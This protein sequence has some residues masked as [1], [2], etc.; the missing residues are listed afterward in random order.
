LEPIATSQTDTKMGFPPIVLGKKEGKRKKRKG[1]G[2]GLRNLVH[3]FIVPPQP[4]LAGRM[5]H[6]KKFC[7]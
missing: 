1:E 2:R 3:S 4:A 7:V 6:G 5:P